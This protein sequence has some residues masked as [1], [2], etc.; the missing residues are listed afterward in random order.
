MTRMSF[1]HPS[2]LRSGVIS[3]TATAAPR[4]SPSASSAGFQTFSSV[5]ILSSSGVWNG[6]VNPTEY[7]K[8]ARSTRS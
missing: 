3:A 2:M 8:R 6:N 4:M 1:G 7:D 5:R